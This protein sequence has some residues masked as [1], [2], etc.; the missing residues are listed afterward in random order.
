MKEVTIIYQRT[1]ALTQF[2]DDDSTDLV[3]YTEKMSNILS[4]DNVV[5]LETS[6]GC[7]ILRPHQIV[8]ISIRDSDTKKIKKVKKKEDVKVEIEE[9]KIEG[10]KLLEGEV[11][12]ITDA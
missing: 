4:L 10:K 11:G 3:E 9:Q 5:T 8:S 12:I 2:L 1:S 7:F 6:S